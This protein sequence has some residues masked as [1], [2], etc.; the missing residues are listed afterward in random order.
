M[1]KQQ[2]APAKAP[3]K[4]RIDNL[5]TFEPIT[6]SQEKVYEAWDEGSHLVMAGTAGTGKTFIGMYL[7]LEY[8]LDK[9]WP[10]DRLIVIRSIVPTRE[11][12]FLPGSIKEK[13]DAY[14]GPYKSICAQLF[15]EKEAFD[16]LVAQGALEFT[17]TSYLRGET[18][19][20]AVILVDE[21]QNLTFHELDSVITRV[22]MNCRV[23]FCGDYHQTD[24]QKKD[25]KRGLHKFIN[26]I[27]HMN[28]FDIVNFTWSDIVRSDFV[29]DYIMTKE[30]L[31][32]TN[33]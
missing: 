7:G 25:D 24:F 29:R 22:G 30:M 11:I 6:T 14:T 18:F 16:R 27:E 23:I 17:S 10:A 4:L 26:I 20:N 5:K 9:Q 8:I 21:M 12:G 1:K 32:I 19:D 2:A 33:E 3:V 31:G 28:K 15:D 13:I